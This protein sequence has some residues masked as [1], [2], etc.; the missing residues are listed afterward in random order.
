ME[1]YAFVTIACLPLR[2]EPCEKAEIATQLL[3]A[4]IVH[5][6][7]TDGNWSRVHCLFDDYIGWIDN[8]TLQYFENLEFINNC[9]F[10]VL[11]NLFSWAYDY[12]EEKVLLPA[13][14]TIYNYN[15][16]DLTFNLNNLQYKLTQPI[17]K[18]EANSNNIL[19]LAKQF[20]NCPY[21]WGG[22]TAFGID[23]SGLVQVV[24]KIVGIHLL[25]DAAQQVNHGTT[26]SFLEE[27]KPADLIFFDN[28]QGKIVHVGIYMGNNQIIHASGK[29]R[30]D[31]IDNYGIY[32]KDKKKYTHKLRVIKRIID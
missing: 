6:I 5:L 14:A 21:L 19:H 17:T 29:V 16:N 22:K 7:E 10:S 12:N 15:P 25:R 26:I 20:L 4:D 31:E 23:C 30:I 32:R 8:K 28:E 24:F 9:N 18:Y 1:K 2:S 27:A 11:D 3:F 13:G